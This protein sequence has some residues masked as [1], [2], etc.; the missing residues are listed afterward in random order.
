MRIECPVC[1]RLIGA[2]FP[3]GGDGSA[4]RARRHKGTA[5]GLCGGSGMLADPPLEPLDRASAGAPRRR[6]RSPLPRTS[7]RWSDDLLREAVRVASTPGPAPAG[8]YLHA[9][10]IL[11]GAFSE[12][13]ELRAQE[14]RP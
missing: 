5:G 12:L 4:V 14:R 7:D 6:R 2:Y 10:R 11:V 1:G 9:R 13:L 8:W 3:A